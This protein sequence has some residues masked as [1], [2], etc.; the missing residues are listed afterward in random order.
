MTDP[1]P[2]RCVII[3]KWKLVME[4]NYLGQ[5]LPCPESAEISVTKHQFESEKTEPES[6]ILEKRGEK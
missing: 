5:L 3:G 1:Q 6:W 4:N 2:S